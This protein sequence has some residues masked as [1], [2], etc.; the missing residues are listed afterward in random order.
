MDNGI[1]YLLGG[2]AIV[3]L[4]IS[5]FNKRNAKRRKSRKFMEGYE[6]KDRRKESQ[7]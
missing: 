5:A 4:A 3:Y 6:R 1:Y 7:E 2:L